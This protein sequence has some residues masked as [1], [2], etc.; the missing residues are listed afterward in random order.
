M[1]WNSITR[2]LALAG[3]LRTEL[4]PSASRSASRLEPFASCASFRVALTRSPSDLLVL[5]HV[6]AGLDRAAERAVRLLLLVLELDLREV[7]GDLVG[8]DDAVLA[9]GAAGLVAR[10]EKLRHLHRQEL[11]LVFL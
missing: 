4:C 9:A 8:R 11:L 6:P 3:S 2:R 1:S 7:E 10:D 5:F